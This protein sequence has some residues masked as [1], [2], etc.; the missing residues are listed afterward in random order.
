[1]K[2]GL[3][4]ALIGG[5]GAL[6]AWQ[7]AL[8][9]QNEAE[10]PEPAPKA[11]QPA[12]PAQPKAAERPAPAAPSAPRKIAG[13]TPMAQRVAVIGLLN[14]R[15]GIA[16]DITLRPGQAVRVGDVVIRL[17][18]C[19]ATAPWEEQKLTGAFVQTDV[20]GRDDKWRRIFSGWLFKESPS[21]NTVQH[22]IYDVWPK[23]CT[24]RWPEI[25]PETEIVSEPGAGRS[26]AK[27]SG[28]AGPA[29]EATPSAASSNDT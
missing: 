18:A 17:R 20:R 19:E 1:V 2:R 5:A 6:A 28:G 26:S 9:L 21:L 22:P 3:A 11:E 12:E 4:W 13:E 24:M 8:A 16:R 15:N 23:S 7:A 10:A 25:G 14:K 27:K 29:P